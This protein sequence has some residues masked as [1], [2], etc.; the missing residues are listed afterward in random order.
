MEEAGRDGLRDRFLTICVFPEEESSEDPDYV[1]PDV[2]LNWT[3]T[4]FQSI[5]DFHHSDVHRK[6]VVCPEASAWL[7]ESEEAQK[8][9]NNKSVACLDGW[10]CLFVWCG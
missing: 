8:A 6:Y 7:S 5:Y 1:A 4:L 2:E 3:S 9:T 10:C